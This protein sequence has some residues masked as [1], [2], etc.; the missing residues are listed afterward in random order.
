MISKYAFKNFRYSA[1]TLIELLVVISIIGILIGLSLIGL[2]GAR[3]SSRDARRKVDLETV[4]SAIEIYKSDCNLYP[5][6]VGPLSTVFESSLI[7]NDSSLS[8]L[9]SNTY[10][11]QIPADPVSSSN[12]YYNSDG[13][14]Y[15]ICAALEQLPAT[16]ATCTGSCGS[17]VCNYKVVNP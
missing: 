14:I 17:S 2:Q 6:G 5:V 11:S 10:L 7:G 13:S 15:E 12:Y 16:P 8:C 3:E 4:R 9:A 1:F